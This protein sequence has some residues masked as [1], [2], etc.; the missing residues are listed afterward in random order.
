MV[1]RA[2]HFPGTFAR[3]ARQRMCAASLAASLLASAA[4][5]SWATSLA[6]SVRASAAAL[7][8]LVQSG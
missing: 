7:R 1:W 2:L 3:R 5:W 6:A 8:V 4:L